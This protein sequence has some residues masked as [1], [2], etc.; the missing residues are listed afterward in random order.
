MTNNSPQ[1]TFLSLGDSYTIGESVP[2]TDRWSVQL[3]TM[4]R[5]QGVNVANPDIIARTGWTTEELQAAIKS[6]G[7]TKTYNLVSLL[8]GV[9]NQYRGQSLEKYRSEFNALL[10]TATQYAGGNKARVFVL[11]TPDWGVTPFA[12]SQNRQKIATEIDAFNAVAR[13]ECQKAGIA[14]VDITPISRTASGD[15]SQIADDQLHFS[16]KMYRQW[17]EKALPL[18]KSWF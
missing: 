15:L 14:Y 8:I 10:Q 12:A 13:E 2:E 5:E 17:A 18:V 4:L 7:N 1:Y 6:S 3:A 9:N 11:S 16:G